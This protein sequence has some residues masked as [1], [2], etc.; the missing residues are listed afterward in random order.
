MISVNKASNIIHQ[1]PFN[2]KVE[3]IALQKAMGR[4]LATDVV[5]DRYFPPFDRVAMDGVCL[6]FED[7]QNGQRQFAISGTQAAGAPP[8]NLEAQ[9]AIEIMTGAS[10]ALGADTVI[11][12]ED[13]DI[14]NGVATLLV[15]DIRHGQNVH[16][17][18]SDRRK[19][20]VLIPQNTTIT[21]PT[22]GV[23]ATVG[24]S[25][26]SV[27]TLPKVII[28]STGDELVNIE[29]TPL[30]HQI[31]KSNVHSLQALLHK[32]SIIPMLLHLPD[33]KLELTKQMETIIDEFDVVLMSG[34]VS[35][36]KFDF[37]PEV[38]LDIGVEKQFHKVEQRP[39][40]P[41]WF[42][43]KQDTAV[44]AFPG[45]PVSTF[46]CAI[47]FFEPWLK[48]SY[49]Q[50]LGA[51]HAYLSEDVTFKPNLTY[52]LQVFV[53]NESGKLIAKPVVGNGSGDLANLTVANAF[54]ELPS[55]QIDFK[56]GQ[57]HPVWM[58]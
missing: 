34:A 55:N 27:Y 20:E 8:L 2:P 28:V 44:F 29:D 38:L 18:G 46:V 6:R 39:G 31:R 43:T 26:V 50:K 15:D 58:F 56:A 45:N 3:S 21:A 7:V 19:G 35:K 36:G 22:I 5:A 54:M 14:K 25:H 16:K 17:K 40:K 12:Y 32:Y 51:Q 42:G 53:T 30:P 10:L 24:Q 49:H 9:T 48:K 47:R 33:E 52:F 11:R 1:F 41:F 23:L 13:L 37:L 57:V 4:I